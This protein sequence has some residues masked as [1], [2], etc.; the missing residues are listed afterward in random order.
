VVKDQIIPTVNIINLP[1][2][3]DRLLLCKQ[4]LASQNITDYKIW[5]GIIDPVKVFRGISQ[6]HKQIVSFAKDNGLP[7]VLIGEDDLMF[8]CA[9][10]FEYFM[11]NKP[12]DYD[13]YLASIYNGQLN[14]DN[15]VR[16]LAG[17][18]F[19]MVHSRFYDTFLSLSENDHIDRS[20][21]LYK[22]RYVVCN[23]FIAIQRDGF[24]DNKRKICNYR[25][26]MK[27]RSLLRF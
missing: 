12:S 10:S 16:D 22:G 5:P 23:P 7:E 13:V 24:S 15:T 27:N 14:E 20:L 11:E 3:M 19:Y 18:T 17:F 21:R 9:R 4:E 25:S 6:A 8:T 1:H 2:R 26:Y